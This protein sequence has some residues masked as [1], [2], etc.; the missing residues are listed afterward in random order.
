VTDGDEIDAATRISIPTKSM[1]FDASVE[2]Y[3][4]H[5]VVSAAVFRKN[6]HDFHTRA[7]EKRSGRGFESRLHERRQGARP[8]RR[9]GVSA[10]FH[11]ASD[12]GMASAF[13]ANLTADDS[14]ARFSPN[15]ERAAISSLPRQSDIIGNVALTYSKYGFFLRLAQSYRGRYLD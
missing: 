2:Y 4:P 8:R 15:G 9:T 5:P 7:F 14:K 13:L 6:L 11:H 1:N 12:P 10:A 3:M